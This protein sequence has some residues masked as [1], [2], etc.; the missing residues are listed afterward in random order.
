MSKSKTMCLIGN[1]FNSLYALLILF[2]SLI[3]HTSVAINGQAY[4]A[5]SVLWTILG[6]V[7]C[8]VGWIGFTQIDSPRGKGW[9]IYF[10]VVG[11]LAVF[12]LNIITAVFYILTFGMKNQA[13]LQGE[14]STDNIGL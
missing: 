12:G 9:K 13:Q 11:I 2:S 4:A 8:A 7:L 14:K 1:I 10:L 5:G 6:L 3:H